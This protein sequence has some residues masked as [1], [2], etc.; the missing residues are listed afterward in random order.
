MIVPSSTSGSYYYEQGR[1]DLVPINLTN[2]DTCDFQVG[3]PSMYQSAQCR[4]QFVYSRFRNIGDTFD[5]YA[6]TVENGKAKFKYNAPF[7]D[8]ELT[9]DGKEA[10]ETDQTTIDKEAIDE[11]NFLTGSYLNT[12]TNIDESI[13][14]ILNR[15]PKT[16][17]KTEEVARTY[18]NSNKKT[19]VRVQNLTI[20]AVS[21]ALTKLSPRLKNLTTETETASLYT[22]IPKIQSAFGYSDLGEILGKQGKL[23][24]DNI[25][26]TMEGKEYNGKTFITTHKIGYEDKDRYAKGEDT[27]NSYLFLSP[28]NHSEIQ[29]D[30]DTIDSGTYLDAN[31]SIRVPIIYQFRMTDYKDQFNIFGKYS[32]PSNSVVK[33]AKFANIIGIDIWTDRN[34]IKPK[35]YDI[36]VYSTYSSTVETNISRSKVASTQTLVNA[37]NHIGSTIGQLQGAAKATKGKKKK[38]DSLL[39]KTNVV[40]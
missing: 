4:G 34:A 31:E 19:I 25:G 33:N 36:V 2:F 27:C 3:S 14:L 26:N 12:S 11:Y 17:Q 7:L 23:T 37:V 21:E 10:G 13:Y 16:W 22:I 28:I 18:V 38:I 6:N 15:I 20:S 5:M 32:S 24:F 30:G 9:Y 29:V 40:K 8:S 1:Y 39:L 35:Q